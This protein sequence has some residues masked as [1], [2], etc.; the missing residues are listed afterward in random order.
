MPLR[1]RKVDDTG[2][3][4]EEQF[5]AEY[6]TETF[7]RHAALYLLQRSK[8]LGL[9]DIQEQYLK[10][11]RR[12]ISEAESIENILQVAKG[13]NTLHVRYDKS[14][15]DVD[16]NRRWYAKGNA[17]LQRMSKKLRATLCQDLYIHL[18]FVNCGP[19]LLLNLCQ[20]Y[21]I[22]CDLLSEYVLNRDHLLQE[23]EPFYTRDEA[24]QVIT[25]L[26]HGKSLKAIADN[27]RNLDGIEWLPRLE[28]EFLLKVTSRKRRGRH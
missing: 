7:D 24:K 12:K 25:E 14:K 23:F 20:K 3:Q 10:D 19:T 27:I 4:F 28:T 6:F 9:S 5:A 8:Q 22:S 21:T 17:C 26:M 18:D 1:K 11:E 2:N 13:G 16:R 15:T